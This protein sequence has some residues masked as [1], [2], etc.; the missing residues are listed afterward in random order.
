MRIERAVIL[1]AGLGTRLK[2]LTRNRPKALMPVAGEPAIVHVIRGLA[3]QGV[4]DIAVN[5]HHHADTLMQALGDGSRYG[6]RLYFSLE[7]SLLDSGGGVRAALEYLP[8][9]GP[10][11]VHNADVLCRIDVRQLA[12]TC[13]AQGCAIGLVPNPAHHAAGDFA[14]KNGRVVA[15]VESRY[16]FAGVSLW[17]PSVLDGYAVGEKF[18]L[19]EP[20]RYCIDASTCGGMIYREGWFDIGRPAD[21]FR[22]SRMWRP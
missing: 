1:A 17:Y 22:A 8:G 11:A 4:R 13:P 21:L 3:A 19:V 18:S 16:T 7:E 2:W 10:V 9:D 20:M 14:L 12:K 15:G 5:V 6:V